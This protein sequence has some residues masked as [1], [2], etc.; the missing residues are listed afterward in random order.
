M[1]LIEYTASKGKPMI[2]S[3]GMGSMEEIQDAVDACSREGNE[4][5]V[6]LKCTSEYPAVYEDMNIATMADMR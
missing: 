3:C 6:L 1:P 2:I 5:I 4:Q